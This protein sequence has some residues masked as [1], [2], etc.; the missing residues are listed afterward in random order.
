MSSDTPLES[1]HFAYAPLGK[2]PV[3]RAIES[4]NVSPDEERSRVRRAAAAAGIPLQMGLTQGGHRR[5]D[6][7]LLGRAE[8][9]AV[10]AGPL[11]P[12]A[13]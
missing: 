4:A 2:G 9:G 1:P 8:P 6:L 12:L 10:V 3:F 11:Q 7:H 13:R 5:L